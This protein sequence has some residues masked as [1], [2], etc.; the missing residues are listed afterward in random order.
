MIN[1][2]DGLRCFLPRLTV[3]TLNGASFVALITVFTSSWDLSSSFLYVFSVEASRELCAS[4]AFEH[5]VKQP[6]F[7]AVKA[8]YLVFAVNDHARCNRL[9]SACRQAAA[10]LF[11]KQ[12]RELVADKAVEQSARLLCIDKIVVDITG[13]IDAVSDYLFGYLIKGYT[14]CSFIG[15]RKKLLQV[16]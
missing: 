2:G 10:D 16:P 8:S 13:L 11:P 5:S 6:V 9:H 3:F 1:G 14:S 15:K 12:R 4:L 7:L